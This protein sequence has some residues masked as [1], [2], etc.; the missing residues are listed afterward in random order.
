MN[1]FDSEFGRNVYLNVTN[2]YIGRI[3][4]VDEYNGYIVVVQHLLK[5]VCMKI[6]V[7]CIYQCP[8]RFHICGSLLCVPALRGAGILCR[9]RI[10]LTR[11]FRFF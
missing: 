1:C 6:L 7:G 2:N 11:L 10:V 3:F 8:A 4:L 5:H 9:T